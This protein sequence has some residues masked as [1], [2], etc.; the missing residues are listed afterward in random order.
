MALSS[1]ISLSPETESQ[2][3][4][5]RIEYLEFL[6]QYYE[7]NISNTE[8]KISILTAKLNCLPQL[9]AHGQLSPFSEDAETLHSSIFEG[10]SYPA[11]LKNNQNLLEPIFEK[12]IGKLVATKEN[13]VN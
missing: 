9:T 1:P 8:T 4:D 7:S 5:T 12:E 11:D 13:L 2:L 6:Q 10:I 3:Y